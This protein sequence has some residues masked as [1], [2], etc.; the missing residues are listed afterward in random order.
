MKTHTF[1]KFELPP[2]PLC[3]HC[4][5]LQ[6]LVLDLQCQRVLDS[7]QYFNP[8]ITLPAAPLCKCYERGTIFAHWWLIKG[9]QTYKSLSISG[10]RDIKGMCA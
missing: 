3:P 4:G 1:S 6:Y 9:S 7:Y 8:G 5:T 10:Y 2:L